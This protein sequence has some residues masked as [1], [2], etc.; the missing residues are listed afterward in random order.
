MNEQTFETILAKYPELI[1]EG[2]E[3]IGRQ[4]C[5]YGRRMDL[6]FKDA[7]ER[8]L[9]IELKVGPIKDQH[10]GQV[11]SYEGMLLSADDSSIR[12]MLIGNRVPNNLRRSL[13]HHGIAWK[14]IAVSDVIAFLSQ[15]QDSQLLDLFAPEDLEYPCHHTGQRAAKKQVAANGV[16]TLAPAELLV[17]GY[18]EH[19]PLAEVRRLFA[20]QFIQDPAQK[21][22][23]INKATTFKLW[24]NYI[25]ALLLD[26]EARQAGVAEPLLSPK[27]IKSRL[28]ALMPHH[29]DKEGARESS[30]LTADVKVDSP[31]NLNLPCLMQVPGTGKYKFIAFNS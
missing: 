9:L 20:E 21:A 3:L 23:F 14:E 12:I 18:H 8:K 29:Y 10:I 17:Q 24:A 31:Y 19:L 25:A 26:G 2:L 15:K 22:I 4:I 1:E 27:E 30:L 28:K 7:F 11:M 5:M 13:D 6:L 16:T